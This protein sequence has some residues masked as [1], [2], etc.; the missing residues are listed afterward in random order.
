MPPASRHFAARALA[1]YAIIVDI[2]YA[3]AARHYSVID[4]AY[5]AMPLLY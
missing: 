4:G 3:D 1:C 5:A 2:R